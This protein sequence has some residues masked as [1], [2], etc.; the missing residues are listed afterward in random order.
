MET[1]Y[2]NKKGKENTEETLKL[3]KKVADQEG[4][5]DVV[6]AST[7]GYTTEKAMKIC[8]GL[9]LIVVGIERS[10]FPSELIKRLEKDGNE[11]YFSDE[12]E[13]NYPQDMQTAF[14]RFSQGTKVVVEIAVIAA[15]KNA[16]EVGKKIIA[17]AGT[18]E[19]ADT[20]LVINVAENFNDIIIEELICKPH[21]NSN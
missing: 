4:I 14:R 2:F 5:N 17:V 20:A 6:L 12:E 19:G 8:E 7:T 15:K 3:A 13:Y 16:V 1:I 21:S 11:V 10:T 18:H 9:K